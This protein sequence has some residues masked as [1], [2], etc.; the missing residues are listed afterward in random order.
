VVASLGP[1]VTLKYHVAPI[2]SPVSFANTGNVTAVN[3]TGMGALSVELTMKAPPAEVV[4]SSEFVAAAKVY[5]A[6]GSE[7]MIE[8]PA[9]PLMV[10]E[11]GDWPEMLMYQVTPV[12]SP[13]SSNSCV[14]VDVPNGMEAIDVVPSSWLLTYNV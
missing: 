9:P 11:S 5:P 4:Q 3:G 10:E 1:P 2:G 13:D 8:V 14:G 12:G 6:A 7:A